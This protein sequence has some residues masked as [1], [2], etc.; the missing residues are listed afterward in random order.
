MSETSRLQGL[1]EQALR[2]GRK[3]DAA[4]LVAQLEA[5]SPRHP[6]LA[7][8]KAALGSAALTVGAPA[9]R[10]ELEPPTPP[11]APARPPRT[12]AA[13][14]EA[15]RPTPPAP[16]PAPTPA[17]PPPPAAVDPKEAQAAEAEKLLEKYLRERKQG[18]AQFALDT[19]LELKPNHPRRGDFV[20]WVALLDEEV[21]AAQRAEAALVEGRQA[22]AQG[23]L[24][25]ARQKLALVEKND[26]SSHMTETL[27]REIQLF[28]R[29]AKSDAEVDRRRDRLED[30]IDN[31][32]LDEAERELQRLASGGL[33]KVSVET[34]RL[35]ISDIAAL[36]EREAKGEIEKRYRER[37]TQRDWM[38]AR[39][40]A[41]DLERVLPD[42][43]RPA[44][45]YSEISRLE[46]IHRR[47]QGLEQ[48][49]K[50][51]ES[52]IAD[53][54]RSEAEL[55]LKVLL[56]MDPQHPQRAQLE[57]RVRALR[58]G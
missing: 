37:V 16:A 25:S 22:L 21:A 23:D 10:K 6:G 39:E 38:S 30:L 3:D 43:Q 57:E 8:L 58:A 28:E 12:V 50:Q 9:L 5:I 32:R 36:A 51:L 53:G 48:G 14:P 40:A 54:R 27:A 49:L 45:M 20:S 44:Q 33:A 47:H 19:L 41:L 42:S 31:R 56:Q 1:A 2:A 17:A 34:Y 46:E 26:P 13:A 7:Q 35:R 24:K 11:A 4:P 18:L 15:P 55:A 52:Y 29:Q